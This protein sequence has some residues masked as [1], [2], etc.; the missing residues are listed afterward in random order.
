MSFAGTLLRRHFETVLLSAQVLIDLTV[1]LVACGLAYVVGEHLLAGGSSP[2][3]AW[4]NYR[5]LWALTAALCLVCF[6]GFGMYSPVKSLLNI[7]EYKAIAKSTVL[8]FLLLFTLVAFLR[9]TTQ[10]AEGFPFNLLVPIHERID[11]DIELERVSRMTLVLIFV[12]INVLTVLS[13]FLS[14]KLIQELYRRGIGHRNVIIYGTGKTARW[15]ERKFLLVPTL[16]LRLVGLISDDREEVGRHIERSLVLG[17]LEDMEEIIGRHKVHEAFVALPE[18]SEEHLMEV[19]ARLDELGVTYRVVP[20]FYHL[21]SQRVRIENFH[22]IPLIS[23]PDRRMSF[24]AAA[25]KRALDLVVA[26]AVLLITAPVFVC[27][28]ILIKRETDGPAIFK[29]MRVGQD[30][31]PFRMFKFRTMFYDGSEDA[32]KPDTFDDPRITRVGRLLRRYSL[33]ELPQFLNVLMGSMSIVGPRP[34]MPFIVAGYGALE[35]ERLRAK[36]GITGLWQI[37]YARQEAIHANLDYDIYYV[38]N[39]SVLLDVVIIVLTFF[40]VVKG[41]GAH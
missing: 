30:G 2:I 17:T 5:E 9:S 25:A 26:S 21:L 38:E 37:S 3:P 33:D 7:E 18:S 4:Q 24:V 28:A 20:R 36:P 31:R 40:A 14:F 34:E 13:R 10:E 6:H 11:L 27:A 32:T 35:R 12:L 15:L 16:G 39:R 8:A 29:Q 23:R 41:T 22:S 1:V 19:I